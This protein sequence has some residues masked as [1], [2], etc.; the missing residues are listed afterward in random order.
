MFGGSPTPTR[1]AT[2]FTSG[3]ECR[4]NRSRSAR[5]PDFLKSCQSSRS[6]A[7]AALFS[8]ATSSSA[9]L[10]VLTAPPPRRDVAAEVP[11]RPWVRLVIGR[12]QPVNGHVRVDLRRGERSVTEQL[13]N[14]SQ[15]SPS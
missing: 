5:S 11:S 14:G 1:P 2:Y 6:A 8:A 15:V 9:V 3:E 4:I 13:L 7:S 10:T 12:L